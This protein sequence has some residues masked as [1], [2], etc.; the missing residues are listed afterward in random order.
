MSLKKSDKIIAVV[1]VIILICAGIGILLYAA[2]VD[3]NEGKPPVTEKTK[4]FDITY[5]ESPPMAAIPDNTAYSIKPRL[6]NSRIKPYVGNI[7]IT[8]KNLKSV[9]F[10]VNWNDNI[11]GLFGRIGNIG[12]DTLTV[13]IKDSEGNAIVTKSNRGSLRVNETLEIGS[14]ISL[15]PIEAEDKL[16]AYDI[17]EERYVDYEETYKITI[18]LKTGF[19]GKFREILKTDTFRLEVTYTYYEYDLEG[20]G[21][22]TPPDEPDNGMPPLGINVG[23]G[24]YAATNF[25][26]TKL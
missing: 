6:L 9:E 22:N 17:L 18:S 8:Q 25:G 10:F 21:D 1:G 5:Q 20:F 23:V 26:L 15:D 11:K 13:S 16:E 12:A 4:T 2:E 14:L 19:W 24:I 7:I 3:E